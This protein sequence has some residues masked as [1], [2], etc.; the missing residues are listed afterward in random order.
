[1][2]TVFRYQNAQGGLVYSDRPPDPQQGERYAPQAETENQ[3]YAGMF[4]G[5]KAPE[6]T[7]YQKSKEYIDATKK[8]IPKIQ[9]YMDVLSYLRSHDEA[10]LRAAMKE[11]QQ[12]NP[13]AWIELQKSPLFKDMKEMSQFDNTVKAGTKAVAN[14]VAGKADS[15]SDFMNA[16]YDRIKTNAQAR[17]YVESKPNLSAL[18]KSSS[19]TRVAAGTAVSRVAGTVFQFGMEA[20]NPEVASSTGVIALRYRLDTLAGIHPGW[21]GETLDMTDPKYA[22]IL[23]HISTGDYRSAKNAMDAWVEKH[24]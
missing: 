6:K 8:H 20:L 2:G 9:E 19:A 18:A 16:W 3:C 23:G 7:D 11:L 13:R 21:S 10:G 17:G 24:R 15:P 12:K 22:E 4:C 14:R 5:R 1:M